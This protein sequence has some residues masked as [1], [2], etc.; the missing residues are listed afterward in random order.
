M[1]ESDAT[2]KRL[3]VLVG[4]ALVSALAVVTTMVLTTVPTSADLSHPG[5]P[6]VVVASGTGSHSTWFPTVERLDDGTLLVVY[7][8]ASSHTGPDGRIALVRSRDRGRTWSRPT[9]AVDT[10]FDDRD[11][12]V[13]ALSNGTLVLSWFEVDW[14]T[15]PLPTPG[16]VWSA[17]STDGGRTWLPPVRARSARLGEGRWTI[18]PV[19]SATPGLA[20]SARI[21]ELH[22]RSLLL[23]VYGNTPDDPDGSISLLRSV[24][25]GRTWPASL[26]RPVATHPP[27][28]TF[29]EPAL[30]LLGDGSMQL[31]IRTNDVGYWTSSRDG[32]RTWSTPVPSGPYQEQASDL[33]PV[34]EGGRRLLLQTWGDPSGLLGPGRPTAGRVITPDGVRHPIRILYSGGRFDESYPSSVQVGAGTFFTVFYD[35]Q[36]RIIGGRYS[37]ISDYLG[38][39]AGQSAASCRAA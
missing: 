9:V 14:S 10:P 12:S 35:A 21:V 6:D 16:G 2:R 39:C 3:R 26:E 27:G 18:P 7:Y 31:A 23:P 19:A 20:T 22:D 17:R 33:L 5:E 34:R 24:D 36:R 13:V 29:T 8:D 11:P 1:L 30:A 32:G 38:P 15:T 25:G 4:G 37:H 28:N